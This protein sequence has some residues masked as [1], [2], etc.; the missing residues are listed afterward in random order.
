MSLKS[1]ISESRQYGK[2]ERKRLP[3]SLYY[4]RGQFR[5]IKR[6]F[7]LELERE[8]G[9]LEDKLIERAYAN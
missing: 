4:L 2:N 6:E 9:E 3:R 7:E 5:G 1:R 8:K